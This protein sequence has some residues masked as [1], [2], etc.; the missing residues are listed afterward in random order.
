LSILIIVLF[1]SVT[2]YKEWFNKRIMTPLADFNEQLM[3][4]EPRERLEM[5][6]GH[7]YV[8][9]N[10][11]AKFLKAQKLEKEALVL[12]PPK[13]YIK[14]VKAEFPVPEP[15]VFYYY[16]G[17]KAVWA[18]SKDVEKAN[19]V[20]LYQNNNLQ[21][22]AVNKDQLREVLKMFRQFNLHL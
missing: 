1:F 10:N 9:S 22:V 12:L 6:H 5:R 14:E 2:W 15:V 17:I 20:V 18:N 8:V 16:T 21:L 19:Y 13:E 3:Y 11:I 7:S 4:M